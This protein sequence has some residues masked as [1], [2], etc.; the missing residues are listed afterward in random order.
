MSEET[1]STL[2]RVGG[3][4]L[5]TWKLWRWYRAFRKSRR[6][7]TFYEQQTTDKQKEVEESWKHDG[8]AGAYTKPVPARLAIIC[9]LI[10]L[11]FL[12]VLVYFTYVYP[13]LPATRR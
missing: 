3:M 5:V 4:I 2:A 9:V 13:T 8:L 11:L 12:I 1:A 10:A 6:M 7:R